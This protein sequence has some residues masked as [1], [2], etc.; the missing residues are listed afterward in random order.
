MSGCCLRAL[1]DLKCEKLKENSNLLFYYTNSFLL[2]VKLQINLLKIHLYE[3]YLWV[4][5]SNT[6]V[7]T[8][9]IFI[10]YGFNFQWSSIALASDNEVRIWHSFISYKSYSLQHN[11]ITSSI[12]TIVLNVKF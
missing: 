4:S 8:K 10:I 5:W 2:S 3:W 12:I 1:R 6:L 11:Q 9:Y 7:I